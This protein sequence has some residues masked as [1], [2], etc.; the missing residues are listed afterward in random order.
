[1]PGTQAWFSRVAAGG[2]GWRSHELEAFVMLRLLVACDF[3]HA[4][5]LNFMM[6]F[7]ISEFVFLLAHLISGTFSLYETL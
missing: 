7:H 3:T 6:L 1:M 5:A 2:V 4:N